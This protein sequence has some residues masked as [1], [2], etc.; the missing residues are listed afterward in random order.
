VA[1]FAFLPRQERPNGCIIGKFREFRML[2][3]LIVGAA[4][5]LLLS[6]SSLPAGAAPAAPTAPVA[7]T[8]SCAG[9]SSDLLKKACEADAASKAKDN[10]KHDC[11]GN[12]NGNGK[13]NGDCPVSS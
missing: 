10:A 3:R 8:S 6:A 9:M 4:A 11:K 2:G 13:G 5:G 12:G 1:A 7:P